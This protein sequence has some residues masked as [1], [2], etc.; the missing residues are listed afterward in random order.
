M[1]QHSIGFTGPIPDGSASSDIVDGDGRGG[2][3]CV[4]CHNALPHMGDAYTAVEMATPT[5]VSRNLYAKDADITA[6]CSRCHTDNHVTVVGGVSHIVTGSLRG[7]FTMRTT[8]Y[9][10][11]TVAW[12]GTS[13]CLS[14]HGAAEFHNLV[15]A[16][17]EIGSSAATGMAFTNYGRGTDPGVRKYA[18]NKIS[19]EMCAGCHTDTGSF[20]GY[21]LG[22]GKTY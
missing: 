20:V 12:R 21:A 6:F 5:S 16:A 10:V 7:P 9:G 17:A 11:Q 19:D 8:N 14:C 15:S 1:A 18:A 4:D 22:V 3:G 2:L 13:N